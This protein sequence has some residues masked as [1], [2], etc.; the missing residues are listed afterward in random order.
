MVFGVGLGLR[1]VDCSGAIPLPGVAMIQCQK[2][3]RRGKSNFSKTLTALVE[4][5]DRI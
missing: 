5:Y 4:V 3:E 2:K 1:L